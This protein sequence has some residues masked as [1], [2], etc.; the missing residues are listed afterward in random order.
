MARR[1]KEKNLV[2]NSSHAL[3][4][5][6]NSLS[7]DYVKTLGWFY[8]KGDGGK[9]PIFTEI[10]YMENFI[11][12]F[13]NFNKGFKHTNTHRYF[14]IL[15]EDVGDQIVTWNDEMYL[16]YHRGC[17][18]THARVKEGNRK[19]EE[20]TIAAEILNTIFLFTPEF[21]E[22]EYPKKLFDECWQKILFN[23]FHDIL[24]G[25]SIPEVYLLTWKE[26]EFVKEKMNVLLIQRL[27]D[28]LDKLDTSPEDI[29]LYNPISVKNDA[30]I[31]DG[32]KEYFIKDMPPLSLLLMNKRMLQKIHEKKKDE[33]IVESLPTTIRINNE[34]LTI[35]I[36]KVTGNLI[37]LNLKT[38]DYI[39]NFLYGERNSISEKSEKLV[40]K[41]ST[42]KKQKMRFKGA[43]IN[44]FREPMNKGQKYPAWNIDKS[45]PSHPQKITLIESPK[46]EKHDTKVSI[47]STYQMKKSR[48]T[49]K[50]TIQAQ[51]E[52]L[53]LNIK[54]D[55]KDKKSLV[56]Y[57]V[58]LNLK[59]EYVRCEIPYGSI[60]RSRNPRSEMEHGKWE[61][62]MQ[63]WVDVNDQ[64]VGLA[65]L[66]NSKYGLSAN[67]N[68]ISITLLRSPH[69]PKDPYHTREI[70]FEPKERP[71]YTDLEQHN[72]SLRLVPHKGT[73]SDNNIPQ[74]ALAFNNPVL[75]AE[76]YNPSIISEKNTDSRLNVIPYEKNG[77]SGAEVVFPKITSDHPNVIISSFKPSEWISSDGE[78][79]AT[80]NAYNYEDF[81]LP[82]NPEDWRW[83]KKSIIIRVYECGGANISTSIRFHNIS[84]NLTLVAEEIDLLEYKINKKLNVIRNTANNT[85]VIKTMFT[86]FEIKSIRILLN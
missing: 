54:I 38:Q 25:S 64:D 7:D 59:S 74:M 16:E 71:R 51:S 79:Y 42:I 46:I 67:M 34:F 63:K 32:N 3:K 68:G 53:D 84:E 18:T 80:K 83:D 36:S 73:W 1:P 13:G 81:K 40:M 41:D 62:G 31:M 39:S 26:H 21:V 9:G 35:S 85:I 86:P 47:S 58:P 60:N 14:E 17:L 76:S 78:D 44:V 75:Y 23:Q 22:F 33:I 2:F 27:H 52:V 12:Y 43:R 24:P 29:L 57:F 66:N 37:Q 15:K 49:V 70:K 72:I 61:Y 82:E 19:S 11:K 10:Q 55:L 45:Y 48:F 28:I 77:V 5:M 30:L 8:G 56:K 69:Y 20:I 50:Y 65:I 6:N 4:E